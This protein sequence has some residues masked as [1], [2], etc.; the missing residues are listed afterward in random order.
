MEVYR[1]YRRSRDPRLR[2]AI[3]ELNAGLAHGLARRFDHRGEELDDLVQ[4]A[5]SGLLKAIDRFDPDQGVR[6]AT[7]AVPTI[8]GELKR[9]FRDHRWNVRVSRSIQEN[10]LR[11]RETADM[12]FQDL[13]RSPSAADIGRSAG[14]GE[15]EVRDAL[16]A[17]NSFRPM[18]LHD[19][20]DR[21]DSW[22]Q[23]RFARPCVELQSAEDREQVRALLR[24]LPE[25]QQRIVRLRFGQEL[26]QQQIAE[27]IGVSQMQVSRLL[28]QSL[29]ALRALA[30]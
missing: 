25:R 3:V 26:T 18:P 2:V 17:G 14:L 11:V 19:V 6:F 23:R 22:I 27:R 20:D 5:F 29:N 30:G 28:N 10:Y 15:H 4:V 1:R 13:G 8:V 9:H 7:F 21:A 12:L 16:R 24:R